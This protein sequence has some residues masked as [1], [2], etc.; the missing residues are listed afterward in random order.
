MIGT[1]HEEAFYEL[2]SKCHRAAWN[3][4][5]QKPKFERK[6]DTLSFT[7]YFCRFREWPFDGWE[8]CDGMK[9]ILYD[10]AHYETDSYRVFP[11]G[12]S[13]LLGYSEI[14]EPLVEFPTCD[15][16]KQIKLFKNNRV[17]SSAISIRNNW[18][19][20]LPN[21][22]LS[23][24]FV[25]N[26][27]DLDRVKPGDFVLLTLNKLGSL[28]KRIKRWV[29][30]HGQKIML[31]LDESDEITNPYSK[32]AKAALSCF[33]RCRSKLLTTGTSTRNNISEFAP[34]LELLYN[35][36][37]NMIS[38]CRC[39]YSYSK[40]SDQ[41]TSTPNRYHTFRAAGD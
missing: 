19:V 13:D 17:V 8:I 10:L 5:T 27:K 20:V 18:D 37:V 40:D 22:G 23:Y 12:F 41:I 1:F 24:V 25:E 33:R 26:L 31:V 11:V 21:Y 39:V 2:F 14:K 38:W 32:R 9:E 36:S 34:Q 29:K 6:K 7:G 28:R 16:V 15:K 3:D 35:N 4:S 30:Q